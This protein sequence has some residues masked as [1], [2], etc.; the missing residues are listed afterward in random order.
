MKLLLDEN[1]SPRLAAKANKLGI[2]SVHVAHVGLAGRSDPDIFRYAGDND[3]IVATLNAG[4]FLTLAANIDL[5]PGLIVLRVAGLSAN[6]QWEHL[7][8]VLRHIRDQSD[9]IGY[10]INHVIEVQKINRFRRYPLPPD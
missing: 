7:A 8:P 2:P 5:H 4:D 9:P 3:F 10:A 6:E 1:L